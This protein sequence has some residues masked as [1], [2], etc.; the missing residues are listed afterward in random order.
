MFSKID[1]RFDYYQLRIR[2]AGV[3][4]TTFRTF[5][6]HYEFLVMSSGLCNAPDAFIDLMT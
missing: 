3:P 4:K 1:L 5:Y 6:S 2:T